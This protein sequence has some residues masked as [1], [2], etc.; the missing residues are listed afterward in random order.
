MEEF[1]KGTNPQRRVELRE[2]RGKRLIAVA[3]KAEKPSLAPAWSV[4]GNNEGNSKSAG[5]RIPTTTWGKGG[6]VISSK[7]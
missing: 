3:S 6:A 7:L 5:G 1:L 4:L 2:R